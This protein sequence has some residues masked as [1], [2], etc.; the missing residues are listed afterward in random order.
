[1]TIS[2]TDAQGNQVN[3]IPKVQASTVLNKWIEM[4]KVPVE[5]NPGDF[6]KA[7]KMCKTITR[8]L[9]EGE[10]LE[11]GLLRA[12]LDNP[13][14]KNVLEILGFLIRY[15]YLTPAPGVMEKPTESADGLLSLSV[16]FDF[17]EVK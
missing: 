1:M 16:K 3:D 15:G 4:M 10:S 17:K 12:K 9:S 8:T 11:T 7:E 6:I 13:E 14:F 2:I 5:D